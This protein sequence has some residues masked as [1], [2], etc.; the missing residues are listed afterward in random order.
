[1]TNKFK[2]LFFIILSNVQPQLQ[3]QL[4]LQLLVVQ[5][6]QTLDAGFLNYKT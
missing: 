4:Q 1:M 2:Y 6:H 3:L 5:R